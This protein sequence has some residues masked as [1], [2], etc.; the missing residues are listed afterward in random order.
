M[1]N[2]MLPTCKVQHVVNQ[3]PDKDNTGHKHPQKSR[4]TEGTTPVPTRGDSER[5]HNPGSGRN[6]SG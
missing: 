4:G 3:C 1:I 5:R 6:V 2:D